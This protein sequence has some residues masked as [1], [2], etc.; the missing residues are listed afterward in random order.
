M[1]LTRFDRWLREKFAYEIHIQTLRLPDRVPRRIKVI[2]LPEAAGKRYKHLLI[3]RHS[4]DADALINILR[5]NS[6]MYETQIIDRKGLFVRFVAP[7]EKSI[8]WRVISFFVISTCVFFVLMYVKS[9][10]EDQEFRKN[11]SETLEILKG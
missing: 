1:Q 4:K 3:A 8:T 9:L 11:F 10:V 7:K 5:E 2:D 6:Q